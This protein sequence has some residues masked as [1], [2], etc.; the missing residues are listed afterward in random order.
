MPRL[1]PSQSTGA[2]GRFEAFYGFCGASLLLRASRQSVIADFDTLY[3]AF[4][5]PPPAAGPA[6]ICDIDTDQRGR[7]HVTTSAERHSIPMPDPASAY[8]SWIVLEA[9]AA[10]SRTHFFIHASAVCVDDRAILLAGPTGRGKSTLATALAAGGAKPLNDDITAVEQRSGVAEHFP[11]GVTEG[12]I[13]S[14]ARR[15]VSAVFFLRPVR[16]SRGLHLALDRLPEEWRAAP[17]WQEWREVTIRE[18]GSHVEIETPSPP[19]GAS[20]RLRQACSAAGVTILRD[21]AIPE[22]AFGPAPH[23]A[24]MSRAAATPWL[25]A[26]LV[27][28]RDRS[29]T[30]LAWELAGTFREATFWH[31]IPGPP[32]A[33]AARVVEAVRA[34]NR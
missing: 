28:R 5:R 32:A 2:P 13:H 9:V 3:G 19:A 29:A 12:G 15:P 14:D 26:D 31:L 34:A 11:K 7:G 33:T 24:A 20:E 1:T 17:P 21:L 16:P 27:G 30:D 25:A 23:L 8:A 10:A 18:P 4:R 22:P 6:V